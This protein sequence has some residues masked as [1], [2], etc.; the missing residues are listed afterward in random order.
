ML[1]SGCGKIPH[2][3]RARKCPEIPFRKV[4]NYDFGA[5]TFSIIVLSTF[6]FRYSVYYLKIICWSL[7]FDVYIYI[8]IY[9][10]IGNWR[11]QTSW[12]GWHSGCVWR[13]NSS[14]GLRSSLCCWSDS[15]VWSR[16]Q[17]YYCCQRTCECNQEQ[18]IRNWEEKWTQISM[19]CIY[20]YP[21]VCSV[22]I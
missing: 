15:C 13:C 21:H 7:R 11:A 1:I 17:P 20:G 22:C 16:Y 6:R 12:S 2:A 9:I 18:L 3:K 4:G 14:P 5:W 19:M 10:Y 8:Y